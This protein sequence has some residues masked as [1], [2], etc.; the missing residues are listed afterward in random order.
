MSEKRSIDPE[1][2]RLIE[3]VKTARAHGDLS[4]NAEYHAAREALALY[5][6]KKAA[7]EEAIKAEEA[8]KRKLT[9]ERSE[10]VQ[11]LLDSGMTIE[12]IRETMPWMLE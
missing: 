11:E 9:E 7:A 8:R 1:E 2:K 6:S 12:E 3:A 10:A 5:R 4:E